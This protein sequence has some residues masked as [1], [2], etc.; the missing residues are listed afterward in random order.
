MQSSKLK[1][2]HVHLWNIYIHI[3]IKVHKQCF[4]EIKENKKILGQLA[5]S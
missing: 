3:E 5:S 4:E 1:V 2:T